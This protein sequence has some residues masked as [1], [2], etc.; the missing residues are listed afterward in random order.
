[1]GKVKNREFWESA[2]MNNASFMLYF[3]RLLE[4]SIS[5]WK[6]DGLPDTIDTR[7][8]ELALFGDG[9]AVLFE[10]EVMGALGLR[11][12]AGSYVDVYGIPTYRKAYADNGYQK[13]LSPEDSVIIWNNMLHTNTVLNVEYYARRLYNLDRAIDV[14]AN[15]QKTPVLIQCQDTQRLTMKNLYKAYE[16][17]EPFIFADKSLDPNSLRVLKTDAPYVA[18]KLYTLRTDIWNEALTYLGI[19]NISVSKKER[20]I[21]DEV[22]RG[23][24]GTVACRNARLHMRERALEEANKMFG[25][26]ATVVYNESVEDIADE[27]YKDLFGSDTDITPT[28]TK[29]ESEDDE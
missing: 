2:R 13:E 22:A 26:N 11:C 20:L 8:L 5:M 9:K 24:G 3:N 15:A 27:D 19:S 14:N 6:Y 29:K 18:D 16:G 28:D 7:F 4:L 12:M 21:T 25:W 10:D 17:N 23:M 1:M